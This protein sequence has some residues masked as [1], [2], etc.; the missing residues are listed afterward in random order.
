MS[1][2]GVRFREHPIH[3]AL[4]PFVK[5]IWSLESDRAVRDAPRE[6]ILPDG[7][8][9]LVFHFHDPFLTYSA[10]G[11]RTL[12]PRSFVVGQMRRFLEIQA[13]GRMGI[14]AVRFHVRG[15]YRFFPGPL[16]EVT[17]RDADLEDV[18]GKRARELTERIATARTMTARAERV[19]TTLLELLGQGDRHDRTVDRCLQLIETSD[20]QVN[21]GRL[22][23]ELGVS[24][25][26]LSRRFQDIVGMSPKEFARVRRFLHAVR[27]L[28]TGRERT[29][30]DTAHACG[31]FDQAHFNHE[32]RELAG[33]TPREFF[34]FPHLAF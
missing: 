12:Q 34:T 16:S 6:R 3:P 15:A 26:Q 11:T 19:E 25:R 23:P 20:G 28:S 4:T 5:C 2:D 33:I 29:L 27:A 1:N 7:C 17:G 9:E 14:F 8:V 22:A 30:T 21:I 10:T 13:A 32:F 18:W 31:Y 24:Q